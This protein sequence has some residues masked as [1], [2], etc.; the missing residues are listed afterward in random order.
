MQTCTKSRSTALKRIENVPTPPPVVSFTKSEGTGWIG[1]KGCFVL[2]CRGCDR[3]ASLKRMMAPRVGASWETRLAIHGR[4]PAGVV[5]MHV[6]PGERG[7][8][9][10]RSL[11]M[12]TVWMD[13]MGSKQRGWLH[14]QARG[15]RLY[16][17]G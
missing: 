2:S 10:T 17:F 12:A 8:A 9:N 7:E 1:S 4:T 11:A 6:A 3:A 16:E 13:A 15:C 5:N 14:F